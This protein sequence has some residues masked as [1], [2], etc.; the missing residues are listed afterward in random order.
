MDWDEELPQELKLELENLI[1]DIP[2]VAKQKFA[3]Y[4]FRDDNGRSIDP[5]AKELW[6][7]H[8]FV[9]AGKLAWGCAIY[10]RYPLPNGGFGAAL[11]FS[12]TRV[13]PTKQNLSVPR[14]ELNSIVL[15]VKHLL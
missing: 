3:R 14:K 11:I 5:P 15:G 8:G 4:I 10:L 1:A 12:T 13:A 9:D 6:E 2:E 7:L